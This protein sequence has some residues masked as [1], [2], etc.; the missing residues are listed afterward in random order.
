MSY[1]HI[2]LH[3][4]TSFPHFISH[5][6]YLIIHYPSFTYYLSSPSSP[7]LLFFQ[8][9]YPSPEPTA[10]PTSQ[11]A[12]V[13]MHQGIS[14]NNNNNNNI[15]PFYPNQ[16]LYPSFFTMLDSYTASLILSIVY[17]NVVYVFT[18]HFTHPF[19]HSLTN[20]H[21]LPSLSP[22]PHP[23]LLFQVFLR[24]HLTPTPLGLKQL[25][26]QQ[27]VKFS[28]K[29]KQKLVYLP[30][31]P[32]SMTMMTVLMMM[33]VFLYQILQN[34]P[35]HLRGYLHDVKHNHLRWWVVTHLNRL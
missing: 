35:V 6:S 12:M 33:V 22:P 24:R 1:H 8:T 31:I 19:T 17:D 27:Y 18:H 10:N 11:V 15:Q 20:P 14:G 34:L 32:V 5:P 23:F 3:D 25:S 21:P 9:K 30:S 16:P 7:L 2:T 29:M 13:I 28:M 26:K 4:I